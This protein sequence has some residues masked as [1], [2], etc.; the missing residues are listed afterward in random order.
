MR[1]VGR[2]DCLSPAARLG[3]INGGSNCI[4]GGGE[5]SCCSRVYAASVSAALHVPAVHA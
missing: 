1:L 5:E 4:E 3:S 2:G